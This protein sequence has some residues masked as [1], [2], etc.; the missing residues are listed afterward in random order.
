MAI[1]SNSFNNSVFLEDGK[2]SRLQVLVGRGE[3][4]DGKS[5]ASGFMMGLFGLD[6]K[7]TFAFGL[8]ENG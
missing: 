2:R 3:I 4:W 1:C 8:F 6:D 5:I 7:L